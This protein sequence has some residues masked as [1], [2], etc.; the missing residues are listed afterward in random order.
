MSCYHLLLS[1]INIKDIHQCEDTDHVYVIFRT[2]PRVTH[3][4]R[5]GDLVRAS[6][7]LVA[8]SYTFRI[9]H[10]LTITQAYWDVSGAKAAFKNSEIVLKLI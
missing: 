10:I 2:S 8:L 9:N 5:A 3:M 6:I 1:L 4:V 7:T